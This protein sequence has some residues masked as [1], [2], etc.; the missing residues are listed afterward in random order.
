M[1]IEKPRADLS[2]CL[3]LDLAPRLSTVHDTFAH[4]IKAV[5]LHRPSLCAGFQTL[6]SMY[7]LDDELTFILHD[8]K[9]LTDQ[10]G[11]IK[12][13][14]MAPGSENVDHT[15]ATLR[16]QLLSSRLGRKLSTRSQIIIECCRLSSLIHLRIIL[17]A[18]PR[19]ASR[20]GDVLL[21]KL[22]HC[23]ELVDDWNIPDTEDLS[24]WMY[25]I[26][27]IACVSSQQRRRY[28]GGLSAV[29][30]GYPIATSIEL[31][32]RLRKFFWVDVIYERLADELWREICLA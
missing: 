5:K 12:T 17:H 25:F 10:V 13:A 4:R 19:R 14:H 11:F 29:S 9:T 1:F 6:T 7:G 20:G 8:V 24:V 30:R 21:D 28:V 22:K 23:I 3:Q 27:S 32:I 15:A 18:F 26:C 2:G 16:R 31:K